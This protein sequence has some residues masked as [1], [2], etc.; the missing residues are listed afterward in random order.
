MTFVRSFQ[1][2]N[3]YYRIGMDELLGW[4]LVSEDYFVKRLILHEDV[5]AQLSTIYRE[6]CVRGFNWVAIAVNER[7]QDGV[8]CYRKLDCLP[9]FV[10]AIASEHYISREKQFAERRQLRNP[11]PPIF[12]SEHGSDLPMMRIML[13]NEHAL[14]L[15]YAFEKDYER[16]INASEMILTCLVVFKCDRA[17]LVYNKEQQTGV[18]EHNLMLANNH[19]LRATQPPN[20]LLTQIRHFRE[21]VR[22]TNSRFLNKTKIDDETYKIVMVNVPVHFTTKNVRKIKRRICSKGRSGM[23]VNTVWG[24]IFI[25]TI[26]YLFYNFEGRHLALWVS[27]LPQRITTLTHEN[28]F[29]Y[30]VGELKADPFNPSNV[31]RYAQL[32][33]TEGAEKLAKH[34]TLLNALHDGGLHIFF[35][36]MEQI[37][38]IGCKTLIGAHLVKAFDDTF[39]SVKKNLWDYTTDGLD[40]LRVVLK[41]CDVVFNLHEVQDFCVAPNVPKLKGHNVQ[42]VHYLLRCCQTVGCRRIV[43]LS[44]VYLQASDRWPNVHGR[45]AEDFD[46]FRKQCPFPE[47]CESKFAAEQ[48]IRAASNDLDIQSIIARVGPLYGEGDRHS[49][50]CDSILLTKM[51]GAVPLIG[52]QGGTLQFT[53]AGNAAHALLQCAKKFFAPTSSDDGTDYALSSPIVDDEKVQ[54]TEQLGTETVLISDCTPLKDIYRLLLEPLMADDDDIDENGQKASE[55]KGIG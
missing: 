26:V 33:D 49:L 23:L 20:G 53:Y 52:D 7:L 5:Q 6:D 40:K 36:T 22:K 2:Y 41:N 21:T 55:T 38:I 45:E 3:D 9:R 37:A 28:C 42:F 15:R 46:P 13:N 30:F 27:C 18:L 16:D 47:Y 14:G 10:D 12:I 11:L 24:N 35:R 1:R 25:D 8:D 39:P 50:L 32:E 4:V 31:G 51:I 43:H 29:W 19:R 34:L 48:S 54:A 17:A 44:S